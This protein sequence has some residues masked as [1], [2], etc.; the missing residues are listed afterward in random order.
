MMLKLKFILVTG[1][2]LLTGSIFSQNVGVNKTNPSTALDVNGTTTVERAS[3]STN[4]QLDLKDLGDGYSRL[5]FS[6]DTSISNNYWILAGRTFEGNDASSRFNLF[7]KGDNG[8]GDLI[9]A[10]GEGKVG[11]GVVPSD[12]LHISA[13]SAE[14]A[15]RVQV[16]GLTKMRIFANGGMAIGSNN[17]NVTPDG[18]FVL[19]NTGLGVSNAAEKLEVNGNVNITGGIM[20]NGVAGSN[21]QLLGANSNG[22]L[23]WVNPCGYNRY[24]CFWAAATSPWVA[25]AG[26]TEAEFEIWGS[27]GGGSGGG[28]GG[29]GGYIKAIVSVT[30]GQTYNITVGQGGAGVANG[31]NM[32]GGNGG[33]TQVIGSSVD[34]S[35]QGGLGATMTNPGAGGSFAGTTTL[36]AICRAGQPGYP[37]FTQPIY[38]G[39]SK[40]EYGNGG[41]PPYSYDTYGKGEITSGS[42]S[43]IIRNDGTSGLQPGGGGGGGN[44]SNNKGGNGY[45][46]VRW[47]E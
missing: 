35:A 3:S 1:F 47:N 41:Q 31:A 36:S 15:L 19:G 42:G 13:T 6:R 32:S 43:G 9:S 18:L 27:G 29:S 33:I 12:R 7:Y 34:L 30:P 28:G 40:T 17:G 23:A 4:P 37:N 16:G 8:S 25:P 38:S 26:V 22:N 24:L 5:K 20:A 2:F 44:Y 21:A 45:V 14:N 39:Y 46:I 10:T 11:L